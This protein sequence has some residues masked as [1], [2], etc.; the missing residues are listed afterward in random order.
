MSGSCEAAQKALAAKAKLAHQRRFG[1]LALM[2][3]GGGAFLTVGTPRK[4]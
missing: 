3:L 1:V 4:I 2:E